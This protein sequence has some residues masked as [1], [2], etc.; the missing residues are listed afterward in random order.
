MT[1][2]KIAVLTA[3][4]G[5][6]G[7]LWDPSAGKVENTGYFAFVD[8][9][10]ASQVW[11]VMPLPQFSADA[12][13][14]ARRN[15][16]IA[17]VLGWLLVPGY[18]YYVWHD[19]NCELSVSP[20]RL[21]DHFLG[22]SQLA[23]WKHAQRDCVYEEMSAIA[24]LNFEHPDYLARTRDWLQAQ[25]YPAHSGL[26]ELTSFVYKNDPQVQAAMLTWWELL[27]KYSSRDQLTFPWVVNHH[28]LDY[29]ILPGAALRYGGNNTLIP[30]VR[31]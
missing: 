20:H 14:P 15:A 8:T 1:Q 7:L 2:H 11:R 28:K 29:K 16:K 26:F 25:N 19:N 10:Q 3:C 18:D 31:F 6:K 22:N 12:V 24:A 13:F 9:P 17:K 21:V 23:L 5:P 4:A 30:Q 27:C